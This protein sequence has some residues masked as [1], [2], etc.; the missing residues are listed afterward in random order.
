MVKLIPVYHMSIV[1]GWGCIFCL[2]A[3]VGEGWYHKDFLNPLPGPKSYF[4]FHDLI[5]NFVILLYVYI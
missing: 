4:M 2:H 5:V 3:V 1:T